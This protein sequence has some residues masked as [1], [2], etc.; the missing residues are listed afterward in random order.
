MAQPLP[1]DILFAQKASACVK[2]AGLDPRSLDLRRFRQMASVIFTRTY[3]AIYKEYDG[4]ISDPQNEQEQAHNASRVINGL[5][6]KTGNTALVDI[7]GHDVVA[8]SHKAIGI[9]V[10]V[11]YAEGNRLWFEKL[12]RSE[13]NVRHGDGDETGANAT[14]DLTDDGAPKRKNG[15]G[16]R[17][18]KKGKKAAA[19]ADGDRYAPGDQP[20]SEMD[21]G[22]GGGGSGGGGNGPDDEEDG[23]RTG[24]PAKARRQ[25][26]ERLDYRYVCH[27]PACGRC[28]PDAPSPPA[29]VTCDTPGR[30]DPR[31]EYMAIARDAIAGDGAGVPAKKKRPKSAP[32]QRIA[33]A[34]AAV[35]DRLFRAHNKPAREPYEPPADAPHVKVRLPFPARGWQPQDCPRSPLDDAH[36]HTPRPLLQPWLPP[37][38]APGSPAG[39][40][41]GKP[42]REAPPAGHDAERDTSLPQVP[43]HPDP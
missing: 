23:D 6:K 35:C 27:C 8:G 22:L 20:E 2:A 11:M 18:R 21:F 7:T 42:R 17:R 15:K 25:P 26:R 12:K 40:P 19:D 34:Q 33:P 13:D 31:E 28:S 38:P 36:I 14:D 39:S 32:S 16:V 30:Y 29:C 43:P 4:I 5:L 9:L 10:G 37:H 41:S 3:Q 1:A 24:S